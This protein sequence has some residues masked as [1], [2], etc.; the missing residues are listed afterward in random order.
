[1]T[2]YASKRGVLGT[3]R[4]GYFGTLASFKV[5]GRRNVVEVMT[6]LTFFPCVPRSADFLA[7][8]AFLT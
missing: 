7:A 5:F 3:E 2:L 1:M 6:L 4:R 8:A